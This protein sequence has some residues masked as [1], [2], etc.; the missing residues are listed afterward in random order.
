MHAALYKGAEEAEICNRLAE[1]DK[2]LFKVKSVGDKELQFP[3]AQKM[4]MEK[5]RI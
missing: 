5:K 4:H 1:I 2:K 3:F